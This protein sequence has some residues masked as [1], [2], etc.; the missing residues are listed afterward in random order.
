MRSRSIKGGVEYGLQS[1]AGLL[2][3]SGNIVY[4]TASGS[5][6]LRLS[7]S[8]DGVI[9][10]NVGSGN[11]DISVIKEGAGTWSLTGA[12]GYTG[13][14]DVKAGRLDITTAKSGGG[15]I[16]VGDLATL[17]VTVAAAGQTLTTSSL[18]LGTA[19]G[20]TLAIDLGSLA[21]PTS[22]LISAT[23]LT[24]HGSNSITIKGTGLSLGSFPLID[25]TG[26]IEGSGFS[27]LTV[28]G[29][30]PRVSAN[31]QN[32]SVNTRV[33]LNVTAFDVPRWTG[34]TNGI[35]DINNSTNPNSG[36]GT[37]NWRES[38]SGIATRYLQSAEVVDSVIFNDLADRHHGCH[39]RCRA[40][41]D[42]RDRE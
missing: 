14:T 33:L 11:L 35:W 5:A 30:P 27:G 29:L 22:P 26:V 41:A 18:T 10:S 13:I 34:A 42:H 1:N 38:N 36:S 3:V 31:L 9:S 39:A 19:L 8:G 7:G 4:G 6:N 17:G 40:D 24:T 37:V 32:D 2:T 20:G 15:D 25:Y 23:D 21:L 12:N 28:S 16:Q